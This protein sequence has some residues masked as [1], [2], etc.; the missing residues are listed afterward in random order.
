MRNV[1]PRV[2]RIA[3][4]GFGSV[5]KALAAVIRDEGERI[6][7]ECGVGIVI[8]GIATRR[9]GSRSSDDGLDPSDLLDRAHR[10]ADQGPSGMSAA[11]FAGTCPAD[12]IVETLPLEPWSGKSATEVIRASMQAGRDVVSANKGPVAHALDDLRSL[13]ARHGV[14]YR[15]ESAVADGLPVFNLIEHTLPAAGITEI[16]GLFNSTSNVV[17]DALAE[18]LTLSDA[19]EQAVSEGIAETDPS[20]DL[21]GLDAAVKLSALCAAVWGR[22]LPL[23]NVEIEAIDESVR[24]R[25]VA[26]RESGGRLVSMGT[27]SL[28]DGT[29]ANARV[30]LADIKPENMF[31]PLQGASLGL[32][33]KSE[34]LCPISVMSHRPTVKDTAYGLLSDILSIARGPY[35][36]RDTS[37]LQ[38]ERQA[39]D[40]PLT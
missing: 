12:L 7:N 16:S 40:A 31:Y 28:V 17:L 11:L 10:E 4:V 5:G 21:D 33:I 27:I 35:A 6:R 29:P 36:T 25:A 15:F 9:F 38:G 20:F 18:G 2:V 8:T 32:C 39:A 37:P 23:E 24:S 13:A 14:S 30:R 34:L 1:P 3:L 26:A 19:I 22:R